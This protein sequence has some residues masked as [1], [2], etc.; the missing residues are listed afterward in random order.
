MTK[1]NF[2][3]I[4]DDALA[5]L[6]ARFEI[7]EAEWMPGLR[8]MGGECPIA[9]ILSRAGYQDVWV[10][11]SLIR[12]KTPEG[13]LVRVKIPH[14]IGLFPRWF[15]HGIWPELD[16]AIRRLPAEKVNILQ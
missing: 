15:D 8:A 7:P 2:E 11:V 6:K 9:R 4:K 5:W 10:G 1:M 16:S 13:L 12:Y 14:R 3:K